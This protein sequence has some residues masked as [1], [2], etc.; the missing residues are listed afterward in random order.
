[1]RELISVEA[2]G[3]G[4]MW[5]AIISP[6]A[7]LAIALLGY[8]RARGPDGSGVRWVAA[9][10]AASGPLLLVLWNAHRRVTDA[11]GPDSVTALLLEVALSVL[12]GVAAGVG[13]GCWLAKPKRRTGTGQSRTRKEIVRSGKG[14][15]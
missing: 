2:F 7:G 1:M 6:A 14:L 4:L 10:V 3:R 5:L 8:A 9:L 15:L 13:V 12:A 11:L